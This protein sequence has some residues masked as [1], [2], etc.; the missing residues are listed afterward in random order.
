MFGLFLLQEAD[1]HSSPRTWEELVILITA[2]AVPVLFGWL[3]QRQQKNKED[4]KRLKAEVG[5]Q[6]LERENEPLSKRR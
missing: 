1:R 3:A 5:L 4:I 6:K 2:G